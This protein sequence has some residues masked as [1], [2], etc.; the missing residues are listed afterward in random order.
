MAGSRC[1]CPWSSSS[2]GTLHVSSN[3]AERKNMVPDVLLAHGGSCMCTP[4]SS[5]HAHVRNLP[6]KYAESDRWSSGRPG[7]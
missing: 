5:K 4:Q 6:T 3:D 1:G 2:P 7:S